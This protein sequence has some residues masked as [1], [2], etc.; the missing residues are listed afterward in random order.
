MNTVIVREFGDYSIHGAYLLD[1]QRVSVKDCVGCW[2]CWL[3]TP[4]RCV[5]NDLDDFYRAFINADKAIFFMSSSRG[6]L[7]GNMKSL[8]DRMIPHYLPYI[9]YQTGE[10][11][12]LK[13]YLHYPDVEVYYEDNFATERQRKIYT[14]Y[15][16]RVF[17]QF[18]IEYSIKPISEYFRE[19]V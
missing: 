19:A 16:G 9:D 5:H 18:Q 11:T 12:H 1:M 17:Y 4:G 7:T 2:N 14:D 3:K 15:I 10:S 6:F 8:F 13:R